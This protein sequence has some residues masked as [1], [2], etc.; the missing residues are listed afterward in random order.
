[1]VDVKV[2][3]PDVEAG[4]TQS[5]SELDET[6]GRMDDDAPASNDPRV[7]EVLQKL[8]GDTREDTDKS[9]THVKKGRD[10]SRNIGTADEE[11]SSRIGDTTPAATIDSKAATNNAKSPALTASQVS[12]ANQM[13]AQQQAMAQQQAAMLAQQQQQAMAQQ[14]AMMSAMN[15]ASAT[16]PTPAY[17]PGTIMVDQQNLDALIAAYQGGDTTSASLG[18]SDNVSGADRIS[19]EEVQYN[20]THDRALSTGEVRSTIDS[21]LDKAGITDP[22]AREKWMFVLE[23]VSENESGDNPSAVNTSDSNAVGPTQVDG[24]PANSSRGQWQTIPSTFAAYHAAGTSTNIYDPEASAAAA[25][26][27]ISDR[28]NVG[29]DGQGLEEFYAARS[30]GGYVGY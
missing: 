19:V 1:M 12:A 8:T 23:H 28:Y 2:D 22:A 5:E 18:A 26:N 30:G 4:L 25:I 16:L 9:S 6:R 10:A 14:Q 11:G 13:Q 15:Q 27:Y 21:A 20:K 24:A 29:A 17:P 7:A 3:E